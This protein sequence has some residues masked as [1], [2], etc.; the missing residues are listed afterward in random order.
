VAIEQVAVALI[1]LLMVKKAVGEG[2]I[3]LRVAM[4]L[5]WWLRWVSAVEGNYKT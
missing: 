5:L 1:V 4:W 2:L 3:V